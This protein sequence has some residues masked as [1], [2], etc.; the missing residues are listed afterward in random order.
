[1][2]R[3][4]RLFVTFCVDLYT[5]LFNNGKKQILP[6]IAN[7]IL[8]MSAVEIS[9]NIK[10]GKLK[11]RNVIEA[12]FE[13][14]ESINLSINAVIAIR[15]DALIDADQIDAK[16]QH[17]LR[18]NQPLDGVSIQDKPLLGVPFS[19]KDS[20]GVKGMIIS[21]GLYSRRNEVALKD[22]TV[23][24]NLRE[25]GA[26]PIAITNVPEMLTWY[27]T[28]NKLFGQTNNPY[29]LSRTPGGTT[30]GEGALIAAAGSVIG[31]GSDI[32]G[33]IRIPA[34]F[35]GIYGHKVTPE[36]LSRDGLLPSVK[37]H[38]SYMFT[39]GPLC[40]YVSDI[41]PTVKAM[42]GSNISRLPNIE[43]RV[44]LSQISI[45]Y[46]FETDIPW[47]TPLQQCVKNGLLKVVSY[48]EDE[49]DVNCVEISA[50]EFNRC[51]DLWR[52]AMLEAT[53]IPIAEALGDKNGKISI[54]F[55]IL[56]S[57]FG[58]SH[59]TP[60]SLLV[61][62]LTKAQ[63]KKQIDF[64]SNTK[65]TAKLTRKFSRLLAD[66]GVF[67]YPSHPE[68]APKHES[69]FFKMFNIDHTTVFNI[70]G[71]P[72]T[73]CPLG[74][75]EDGLPIGLQIASK[76]YNDHLTIAVASEIYKAFGGW[77]SPS[78]VQC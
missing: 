70:M 73:Q 2:L 1:M 22:S 78:R 33:S 12:Y 15:E 66:N 60:K 38:M 16:V 64:K 34:S 75:N 31:V 21:V 30:G 10:Q 32:G 26:I 45:Y 54:S 41:I 61:A 72:V 18:G 71:M 56:K 52:E 49:F 9:N 67:L 11:A 63:M 68:V 19:V 55:E 48:F 47:K 51:I 17:E 4:V 58:L 29:D 53:T 50:N 40:R 74:L 37:E 43:Q 36:I 57:L 39:C 8:L 42:A 77:I 62:L 27:D 20:I 6:P 24:A 13:R 59:H 25:A 65:R 28:Y 46:M 23:V 76:A 3:L 7:P 69:T 44:D 35:C 5:M 14:I